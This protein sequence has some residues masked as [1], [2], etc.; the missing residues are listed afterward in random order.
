M[1]DLIHT[2]A[3][4]RPHQPG[5]RHWLSLALLLSAGLAACGS[6]QASVDLTPPV[7][8]TT[9]TASASAGS[10]GRIS[11]A[12]QTVNA[13]STASFTVSADSGFHLLGVSGCGG[14]L[15]GSSYTTAPMNA[16][17]AISASFE[18]DVVTPSRY[19]ISTSAGAG[20]SI[21][22][23]S[24]VVDAGAVASFT[25]TPDSGFVVQDAS[26][27]GGAR[28][29]SNVYTTAAINADCTITASFVAEPPA[30]L[31]TVTASAGAG[32]QISPASQQVRRGG[33]TVFTVTAD[34]GFR[35]RAVSG[36][37]GSLAGNSYTTGAIIDACEVSASFEAEAPTAAAR[38]LN[39]TGVVY[40]AREVGRND[41]DNRVECGDASVTNAAQQDVSQGRDAQAL[42][43][44]LTKVGASTPN[45][46]TK[47]NGFDF[48]KLDKD[49]NALAADAAFWRCTRDN[50]T[51]LIWENK[52]DQ[53]DPSNP[54][55][56]SLTTA[57]LELHDK[58]NTYSWFNSDANSNGGNSGT[59]TNG[60]CAPSTRC[61][62]E[63][64]VA[65]VNA[66]GLCGAS[67]W[68]LP[69]VDELQNIADRGRQFG[70]RPETSMAIDPG[71]FRFTEY[72]QPQVY[73]S[74]S[75]AVLAEEVWVVSFK[76][77]IRGDDL[78]RRNYSIRLVRDPAA[79]VP[80]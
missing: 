15:S 61:D 3:A 20:G 41:G 19:T 53:D 69:T 42:A 13:G 6:D 7:T 29:T 67:D 79:A 12:S 71:Y 68:R 45:A 57:D 66:M 18:A 39:D 10:G 32:G 4:H 37:G 38:K 70:T 23:T 36:C 8:P 9:F 80:R 44:T 51:G 24:Q 43:G 50:V 47:A 26:G 73:W 1:D 64:F 40:C 25:I 2:A 46:G 49:G 11:P 16:N 34:S 48:T 35:I 60:V 78:K 72:F 75:P 74:S 56:G 58:D 22:P 17:C 14:S 5:R 54:S 33:T 28:D 31:V 63:K 59:A 65:D 76:D 52:T 27:C 21:S 30:P 62:T 77:G 55:D